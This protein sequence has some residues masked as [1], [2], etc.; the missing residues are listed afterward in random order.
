MMFNT[1]GVY[2]V[3]I[4]RKKRPNVERPYK[5]IGY[6]ITVILTTL[7][8]VGL[9]I[10]T[11]IEDPQTSIIGLLVPAIGTLFYFYFDRKNKTLQENIR[12]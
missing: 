9:M 4:Y 12:G 3:M 10:N 8:F 5:V 1:L 7:I 11:F 2:A 6:P